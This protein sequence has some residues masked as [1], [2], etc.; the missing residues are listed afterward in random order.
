MKRLHGIR[1]VAY[2]Q[3]RHRRNRQRQWDRLHK[4]IWK[5]LDFVFGK[6]NFTKSTAL[7]RD[8]YMKYPQR[9]L[10]RG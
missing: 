1:V 3:K 2:A 5:V 8:V 10:S 6:E 4:P 7:Y 9:D